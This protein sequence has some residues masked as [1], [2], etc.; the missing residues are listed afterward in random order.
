MFIAHIPIGLGLARLVTRRSLTLPVVMVA[1]FG[2][3]FPD[4]DLIRFYLFDNHQRH[5]HDYWTHIPMVWGLIALGW[6]GFRK[7]SSGHLGH[8]LWF[9][10]SPSFRILFLIL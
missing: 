3:I 2:A 10:L 5:H 9:S 6:F 4:L 8:Y 7:Y 1:A